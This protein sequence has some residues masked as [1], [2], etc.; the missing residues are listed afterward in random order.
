MNRP[1]RLPRPRVLAREHLERI[2][3]AMLRI[4]GKVGLRLRGPLVT[5]AAARLGLRVHGERAFFERPMVEDFIAETGPPPAPAGAADPDPAIRLYVSQYCNHVHD[6]ETDEIVPFTEERLIEATKFLDTMHPYSVVGRVP[7]SPMDVPQELYPLVQ[8]KVGAL[9]TRL[10]R[11]PPEVLTV[12]SAPYV[13][14]L[15]E[16]LGRPITGADVYIVSPL[17]VGDEALRIALALRHRVKRVSVGSMTSHGGTTPI[18]VGDALAIAT[19]ESLGS[20]IIVRE[21][22]GLPVSWALRLCPFDPRA[23]SMTMGGPESTLLVFANNELQAW[24]EKREPDPVGEFHTQAKLPGAQAAAEKM[25]GLLLGALQGARVFGGLG[26]LSLDEVFS[27]EQVVLDC[28][29]RD[30]VQR[31]I[32]GLDGSCNP[33]ACVAEA[34]A[35][36]ADTFFGLDSTVAQYR[37]FY[38]WPRL[39][40]R[41]MRAEWEQAGRPEARARAKAFVR[42]QMQKYDFEP[43]SEVRRVAE[44]IWARAKREILG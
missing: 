42:E 44:E 8:Y 35:G 21:V 11:R 3:E 33:E 16:A 38:W 9:Y 32:A 27:A 13:M 2:H 26:W 37:D 34:A 18:G 43:E 10:G 1:I 24:Y 23:M 39:F 25:S 20:A 15:A 7:G 14:D 41:G 22:V 12:E 31:L 6:I 19:A 17:T 30:H 29:V 5:E 28:E 4:L 40:F 36:V